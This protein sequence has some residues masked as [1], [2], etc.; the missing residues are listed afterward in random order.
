MN[1]TAYQST[2]AQTK[3]SLYDSIGECNFTIVE[4]ERDIL[5]LESQLSRLQNA[6]ALEEAL[7]EELSEKRQELF[8]IK[9]RQK[10]L[11][12]ILK[13]RLEI[14]LEAVQRE[15]NEP[16]QSAAT[17][18][19]LTNHDFNLTCEIDKLSKLIEA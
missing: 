2:E 15:L 17:L 7:R 18:E 10:K 5:Q 3:A 19:D 13:G 8:Q 14:E 9:A 11:R 12:I 16:Y 6:E 1:T 4:L